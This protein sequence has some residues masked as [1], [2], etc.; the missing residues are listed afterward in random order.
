MK[1]NLWW[2]IQTQ[3]SIFKNR[4]TDGLQYWVSLTCTAKWFSYVFFQVIFHYRLLQDIDCSSL[5]L[6]VLS[7]FSC[8]RLFATLWTVTRHT[9]PS[10]GFSSKNT[11]VGCHFLFQGIFPTQGSK[12]GL[13]HCRR[14]LYRLSHQGSPYTRYLF[15]ICWLNLTVS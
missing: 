12:P 7:H 13:L 3:S 9:P 15:S 1:T 10:M 4:S 5:C 11:G 8:F 2:G 14:F 6:C